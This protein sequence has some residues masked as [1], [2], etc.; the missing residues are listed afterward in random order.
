[1]Q[2]AFNVISLLMFC[3]LCIDYMKWAHKTVCY[4]NLVIFCFTNECSML[5]VDRG[6]NEVFE[7]HIQK[8]TDLKEVCVFSL[9]FSGITFCLTC[10][11]FKIRDD[12]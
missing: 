12:F 2:I 9:F 11:T 1:M 3:H 8:R 4:W 10:R 6:L 7:S 5:Y